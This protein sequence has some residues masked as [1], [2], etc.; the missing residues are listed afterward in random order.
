MQM[1]VEIELTKQFK[2]NLNCY[3]F[4]PGYTV[5]QNPTHGSFG[6]VNIIIFIFTTHP[7][8]TFSPYPQGW[9]PFPNTLY[10]FASTHFHIEITS[11]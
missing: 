11:S 2:K 9:H 5:S 3:R 1:I 4:F 8:K 6:K 7:T 10:P